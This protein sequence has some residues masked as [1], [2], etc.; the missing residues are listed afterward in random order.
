[1]KN[2]ELAS[3]GIQAFRAGEYATA[4]EFLAELI[5]RQPALWTCR[6]YLAMSYQC[7][8]NEH[9]AKEELTTISQWATDQ[10]VKKKAVDALRAINARAAA[11]A[12]KAQVKSSPP[13]M[14]TDM[15]VN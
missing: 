15:L 5:N 13:P 9:K 10:T 11:L 1:M 4:V 6:L 2:D 12:E 3:F 7:H 8:G 14:A